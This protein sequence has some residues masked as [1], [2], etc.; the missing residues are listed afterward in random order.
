MLILT[1]LMIFGFDFKMEKH[2]IDR[3]MAILE[4][5]GITFTINTEIGKDISAEQLEA[6]FDVVL[7]CMGATI[8][9]TYRLNIHFSFH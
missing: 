4:E 1:F 3:R 8:R 7:L 2:V 9:I 6:D 5:E